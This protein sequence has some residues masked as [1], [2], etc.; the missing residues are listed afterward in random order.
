M[1]VALVAAFWTAM[2]AGDYAK[3]LGVVAVAVVWGV[4]RVLA[5][6]GL[7]KM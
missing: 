4:V 2:D 7:D 6:R 5:R 3:L 1:R